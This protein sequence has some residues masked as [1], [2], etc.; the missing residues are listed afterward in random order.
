MCARKYLHAR[1]ATTLASLRLS[2]DISG[3]VSNKLFQKCHV[4][5]SMKLTQSKRLSRICKYFFAHIFLINQQFI[6]SQLHQTFIFLIIDNI[7]YRIVFSL[8]F[9]RKSQRILNFNKR[10]RTIYD[11]NISFQFNICK[12]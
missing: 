3:T 2:R 6:Y 8:Y 9:I 5:I 11:Y 7:I 10:S 4:T 12:S 1:L